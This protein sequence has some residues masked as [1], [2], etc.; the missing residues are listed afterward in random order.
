MRITII[1]MLAL[2]VLAG[3]NKA[4]K[5]SADISVTRDGAQSAATAHTAVPE[6]IELASGESVQLVQV[7]R[8]DTNPAQFEGRVAIA[9]KVE[10]VFADRG[11]FSLADVAKMPGCSTSCC[12]QSTIPMQ[13]PESAYEG[14]LPAPGDELVVIGN[15]TPAD[16]G[17]NFDV[18][19]VRRGDATLI[20]SR[21]EA[22]AGEK[23]A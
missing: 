18:L 10:E 7:A 11:A 3:C 14:E 4:P 23:S 22:P 2:V 1:A 21:D 9:G 8:L 12:S 17:F 6:S 13:V 15:L 19:E 5:S 20:R 16:T